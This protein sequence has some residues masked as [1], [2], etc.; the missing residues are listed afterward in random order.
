MTQE[1]LDELRERGH[2]ELILE[3]ERCWEQIA[4]LQ[5]ECTKEV[6]RR[7]DAETKLGNL[8]TGMMAKGCRVADI[9]QMTESKG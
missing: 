3:V 8:M 2:V 6:I 5:R 1:R 7:R 4:N 9:I